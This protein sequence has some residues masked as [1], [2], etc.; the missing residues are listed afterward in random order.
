V[1][2]LE[3]KC[4][5]VVEEVRLEASVSLRQDRVESPTFD[6][7]QRR[8]CETSSSSI[9]TNNFHRMSILKGHAYMV[10]SQERG[11]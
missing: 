1:I 4:T 6:S 5:T 8:L 11:H 9:F 10:L 2:T 7:R 3:K